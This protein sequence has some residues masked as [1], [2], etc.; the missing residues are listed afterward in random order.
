MKE[1]RNP[2]QCGTKKWQPLFVKNYYSDLQYQFGDRTV[3]ARKT[4]ASKMGFFTRFLNEA[5]QKIKVKLMK[6]NY[7]NSSKLNNWKKIQPRILLKRTLKKKTRNLMN[8]ETFLL[9][10][11]KK[12]K[13]LKFKELWNISTKQKKRKILK[14]KE[15]C[16][17]STLS[18]YR[19]FLAGEVGLLIARE[20]GVTCVFTLSCFLA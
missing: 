18:D 3:K 20:D 16:F 15:L 19:M 17:P 8:S 9:N 7:S 10:Q 6:F 4:G 5:S 13:I 1:R 11:K 2:R 14:F 12:R